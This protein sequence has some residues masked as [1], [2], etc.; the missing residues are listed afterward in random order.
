[1]RNPLL[2]LLA[3]VPSAELL[4]AL[5]LFR[6]LAA[7]VDGGHHLPLVLWILGAL[8]TALLHLDTSVVLLTPL[9]VELARARSMDEG[10]LAFGPV[11]LASLA[12]SPLP[13]SNLT[14]LIGAENWHFGAGQFAN[15][16][17]AADHRRGC[18]GSAA[19]GPR[20]PHPL[21]RTADATPDAR[22]WRI[23][24][25]I[26][27]ALTIGF[28]LGDT[29]GAPFA[30]GPVTNPPIFNG[31]FEWRTRLQVSDLPRCRPSQNSEREDWRLRHSFPI[32]TANRYTVDRQ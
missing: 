2:F 4:G 19:D 11:L 21:G 1:M 3:A 16:S 17:R 6:S 18:R 8:V 7:L 13:A 28:T 32:E 5:G 30:D 23:G 26:I 12:S 31:L 29:L 24:I 27:C 14:N 9:A 10:T 22:A 15:A 20:A 25:Q